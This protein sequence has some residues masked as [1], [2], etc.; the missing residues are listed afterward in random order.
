MNLNAFAEEFKQELK[1]LEDLVIVKGKEYVRNNNPFH[2]FEQGATF[3][4]MTK[5]SV[6]YGFLLKHLISLNDIMMDHEWERKIINIDQ[7]NEKIKDIMVYLLILKIMVNEGM[8]TLR[9]ENS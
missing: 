8:Y 3:T 6:L 9:S 4:G 5:E 1:E 2:N 7:F